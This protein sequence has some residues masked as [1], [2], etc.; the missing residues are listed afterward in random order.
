MCYNADIS[1]KS[2]IFGIVSSIIV[3]ILGN[4]NYI[5]VLLLLS[6]TFMQLIEYFAW[7]NINNPEKN[8]YVS[9]I[10]ALLI[11]IQL[12][13]INIGFLKGTERIIILILLFLGIIAI[14]IHITNKNKF[15][16][17]KGENGHLI[18][19]FIDIPLPLLIYILC[20]YLY[21][22][23]RTNNYILAILLI[24]LL[25]I[26]IYN[27]YKYKTWGSMWCYYSNYI[28]ILY[29][30]LSLSKIR[31]HNTINH[32]I[33]PTIGLTIPSIF[34]TNRNIR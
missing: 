3:L 29:I 19:H 10:G 6:V 22:I 8:K 24:L 23:F 30:L 33:N 14:L 4:I 26:S 1:I 5:Y 32:I 31:W 25:T 2:F 16:M 13:I 34:T 11:F 15:K 17:E 28:W 12:L 9:M 21:A 20:F 18:W 7:N 27:Y